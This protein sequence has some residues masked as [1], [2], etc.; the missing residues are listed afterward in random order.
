MNVV[1]RKS[2]VKDFKKISEPYKSKIKEKIITL[3]DFPDISNI[4][5][6]IN[7]TP[8]YRL[9]VGDYRILFDIVDNNIEV[10][11]IKHRKESY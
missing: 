10:S 1:I 11:R 4:K 6:L 3:Q 7:F 8:I 5:K 9:R 2:A